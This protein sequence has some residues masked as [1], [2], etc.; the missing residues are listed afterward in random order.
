KLEGWDADWQ[1][2]GNRRE[3]FYNNLPPRNY[4]FRVVASNN[5]G[6]WNETGAVLDF[7]IAPAY[8]QTAWFRT[9]AVATFLLL[10]WAAYRI[11]LRVIERHEAEITALNESLMKAQE[12]ERMRIAG[13]LHDGVMQQISALSLM[14]GTARRQIPSELEAKAAVGEVQLK[15]IQVGTEVRHL[16]HDLHPAILKDAGLAEALRGYCQEFSNVR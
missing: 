10:L 13:E 8:Y 2:V 9:L 6:V 5:S 7:S 3:A 11:R 14:L 4:R 16:S 12:Q 15:L 1:D